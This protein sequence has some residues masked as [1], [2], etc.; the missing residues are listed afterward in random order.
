MTAYK[1][2][3][4]PIA[5]EN[6]ERAAKPIMEE[7]KKALGMVPNLYRNM[8]NV[9]ELLETY[10]AGYQG[11]RKHSGFTSAEQEVV[12]LSVS[13]ENACTYCMAVHSFMADRMSGVPEEVTNALR[14]GRE[15]P[16]P[17]LRVLS[18]LTREMVRT[19]GRPS[20]EGVRAFLDAGYEESQILH[21]L[22]A[23]AVKTISN[24]TNHLF[25]TPVD[26]PFQVRAWQPP[27]K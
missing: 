4:E 13:F 1:M 7:A 3:L 9:P 14:E 17:K 8:A 18:E 5:P 12:L 20:E 10:T 22:L 21:V 11:F 27:E 24:Y 6:A 23:V 2:K 26:E 19:R 16:D 15:I 25:E